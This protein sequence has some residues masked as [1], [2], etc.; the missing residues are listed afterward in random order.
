MKNIVL[1]GFMG[2]G[3]SSVGKRLANDLKCGFIDTDLLL[4]QDAGMAVKEIFVQQGE[5]YFRKLEAGVISRLTSGA[6]GDSLVVSTGGGAV[7]DPENRRKL[8]AWGAVICL[9]ASVDAILARVERSDERPLLSVD[10]RQVEIEK[11]LIARRPA[12]SDS[13]LTIDTT[14][15]TVAEVTAEIKAFLK[16][17]G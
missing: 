15:K 2:T 9:T 8:R 14:D 12:Y 16:E 1:T 5:A 11:R 17:R 4:E 3:K 7:V 10:N 13:D 6:Y